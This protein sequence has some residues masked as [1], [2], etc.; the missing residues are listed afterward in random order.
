MR[1]ELLGPFRVRTPAGADV[2]LPPRHR[3]LLAALLVADG[4]PMSAERLVAEVWPD[5]APATAASALQ[6]YVSGLRKA[7]GDRLRTTQAGYLLDVAGDTVDAREFERLLSSA[8][9]R[10]VLLDEALA[11][12]HGP[13]FDGVAAGPAVHAAAARLTELLLAARREWGGLA[14]AA[15]RTGEA[16]AELTGWVAQHPAS[17]PLVA[18]LMLALHRTGRTAEALGVFARTE[19]ALADLGTRA[20]AELATLAEAVRRHDPTLTPP[21]PGLPGGRNRFIGRRAELDRAITLLGTGRLLT[22]AGPGGCGKTRISYEMTREVATEYPGGAYVVELAGLAAGSGAEALTAH[23]A[24]AVG[25]REAAGVPIA[26][27]LNRHLGSDRALLLLDNCEHVR[28][29]VAALVHG[30]LAACPGVRV[31]TTSREPLGLPGEIVLPLGGLALP[32]PGAP[33]RE[34]AR[35]DAVRLLADRVAA[36]RGGT[37]LSAAEEPVAAELC[38]RLDGLPLAL[39]LAAA[40]LRALSLTEVVSRLD[41]R[42]DLLVGQLPEGRHRTMRAAIDWGHDLLD[43]PQRI[44]LR[45]L[46]VFAGG[47][48]LASAQQV[49][50][51]PDGKAPHTGDAVLDPLL[52][53]VDRSLLERTATTDVSRYRMIE[54]IREYAA[55]RLADESTD[56]ESARARSRHAQLWADLLAPPPPVEGPAHA[57]WLATVGA[58]YDNIRAALLWTLDGDGDAELGLTIAAAMWWYW[59]ITGRMLEGRSWLGRALE[60]TPAEATPLRGRALRVA[61]SLA[62]NSGDLEAARALG[63]QGLATF[64]S[65][66]DRAGVIAALNN[67]SITAQ[68]Q[69]DFA[70]SLA[71][72]NESL[73]LAA[74]DGNARAVAAAQNNTAGTL[75]CMGRLDEASALF[76]LALAGFR[77]ITERRGEAAALANLSIVDRRLGRLTASRTGMIESL[78]LYTELEIAEGQVDAIEG[79]AQL[80]ILEARPAEGLTLLAVAERERSTLGAPIFT[81]DEAADRDAAESAAR[82][83]LTSSDIAAAYR[84]ATATS[85]TAAVEAALRS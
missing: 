11:L 63:E 37:P 76:T 59:W 44:V 81:P 19:S 79:L 77:D 9:D 16:T 52:Q 48:D 60:A 46:S 68:G 17:E 24:A 32:A 34:A 54:T 38:R 36:A 40:R 21:A 35:S 49:G 61:A 67:L 80:A 4:H 20:G 57:A 27:T 30:L 84:S 12:W 26:E 74:E 14:L 28:A 1:F 15:G 43:E 64:R 69:S 18:L 75:R 23:V 42:L 51:D 2:P 85:L 39:E 7:I 6:V 55:E 56:G 65:L 82:T 47:F 78:R 13:A 83:A 73:H 72:G 70:A 25:A 33:A 41:R 10:L 58:E 8:G 53:L 3:A 50:A 22:V 71:Y 66:N 5:G 29:D 62:R 45:R 31:V